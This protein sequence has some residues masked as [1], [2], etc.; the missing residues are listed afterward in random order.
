MVF[1]WL[2]FLLLMYRARLPADLR[3]A[4]LRSLEQQALGQV[5]TISHDLIRQVD[6]HCLTLFCTSLILQQVNEG[7][8][9]RMCNVLSLDPKWDTTISLS[10]RLWNYN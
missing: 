5:L 3:E 2:I 8:S 1:L 4:M 7:Q 10:C 9:L 6:T